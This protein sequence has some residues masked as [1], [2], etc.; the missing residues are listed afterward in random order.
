MTRDTQL[1]LSWDLETDVVV[2]GYGYAG[3]IASIEATDAGADVLLLEKMSHPGGISIC[4][5]GGLRTAANAESAFSYL[6]ATCGGQTPDPV[7]KAM[8][9][10]P[11]PEGGRREAY[12]KC[13]YEPMAEPEEARMGLRFTLSHPVTAAIPPGDENLF[14][15][16]LSLAA[17]LEPLSEAEADRMKDEARGRGLLFEYPSKDA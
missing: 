12:P 13:W 14:H 16:A 17:D 1:P 8:A 7:L 4:S 5:G 11:W 10:G 6:K 2:V 3:G 15:L 9:R